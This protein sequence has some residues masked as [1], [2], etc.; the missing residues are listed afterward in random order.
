NKIKVEY[1]GTPTPLQQVGNVSVPEARTII[2]T[3]WENSLLKEIEKA[4]LCSDLGLTPNNDGKSII[5]NFPELTEERRKELSKEIKK[6]GENAKVAVRNVRRDAN[7]SFKKKLK[8]NEISE[9]EQ[10]DYE[11]K[12]QKLTDKYVDSI[13]ALIEGKTKEIMTV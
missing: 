7:D 6:K 10:K 9:D 13:E 5:L 12:I 2:I 1:Y 4:I 11:D 3:P 8:G